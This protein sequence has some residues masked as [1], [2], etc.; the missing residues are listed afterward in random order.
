MNGKRQSAWAI[1][2]LLYDLGITA[3]M[4]RM[5]WVILVDRLETV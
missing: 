1:V 4:R 5:D 2:I 3:K